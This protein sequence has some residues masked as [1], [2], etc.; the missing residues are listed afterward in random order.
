MVVLG[1]GR[2]LMSELLLQ[3]L[4]C[5]GVGFERGLSCGPSPPGTPGSAV[6]Q[7]GANACVSVWGWGV[8]VWGLKFGVGV[9]V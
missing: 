3:G 9:G 5:K 1:G 2:F 6:L 7:S 8:G 4:G